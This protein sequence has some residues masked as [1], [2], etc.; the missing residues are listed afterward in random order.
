L[1]FANHLELAKKESQD[2]LFK[3]ISKKMNLKISCSRLLA[4]NESQDVLFKIISKKRISRFL[5]QDY[6]LIILNKKSGDLF[7]GNNLE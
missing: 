7:F 4:K 5:I 2:F 1:F 3:I 6:L